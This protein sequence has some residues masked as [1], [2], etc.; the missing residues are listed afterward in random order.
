MTIKHILT[1]FLLQM[2]QQGRQWIVGEKS[3]VKH[4]GDNAVCIFLANDRYVQF[5]QR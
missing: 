4:I 1:C 3:E 5:P 2:L